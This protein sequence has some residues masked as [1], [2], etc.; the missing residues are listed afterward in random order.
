MSEIPTPTPPF[1]ATARKA[2]VAGGV[3]AVAAA[4]ASFATAAGDGNLTAS[5][6]L[7]IASFAVGAFAAAFA[8]VYATTNAQK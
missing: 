2:F 7:V 1:F 3:A 6:G 5:E 8:G 4:G